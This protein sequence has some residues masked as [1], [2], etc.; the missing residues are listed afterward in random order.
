[1]YRAREVDLNDC[2][3]GRCPGEVFTHWFQTG[4]PLFFYPQGAVVLQDYGVAF[5]HG[6]ESLARVHRQHGE[7]H[8]EIWGQDF[9]AAQ[10]LDLVVVGAGESDF[11]H[12]ALNSNRD[13]IK[14]ESIRIDFHFIYCHFWVFILYQ[15]KHLFFFFIR[16]SATEVNTV[17]T[18]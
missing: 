3:L 2:S 5:I 9:V 11:I 8:T 12:F 18:L 14:A 15:L 6:D 17:E 10:A 1:M 13:S 7:A 16:H 4:R